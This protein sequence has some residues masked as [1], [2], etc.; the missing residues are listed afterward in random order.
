MRLIKRFGFLLLIAL[1]DQLYAQ[2]SERPKIV[3]GI[4]V[5]QMRFDYLQRFKAHFTEGGFKRLMNEGVNFTSMHY[6]YKPTMTA[7]GHASI[8]TGATPSMHGVVGN[9]WYSRKEKSEVYC[10]K[11]PTEDGVGIYSPQRMK[12]NTLADEIKLSLGD[13]SKSFG[14]SLKDRGAILPAG[15][16]AD[17]AYW[18]EG[19][20]GGFVSSEY[21]AQAEVDWVEAF[22]AQNFYKNYLADGWK[23]LRPQEIYHTLDDHRDY[24]RPFLKG[25]RTAFPYALKSAH[26]VKGDDLIKSTPFG[27]QLLADFAKEVILNNS[28][29]EDGQLDFFSISFSSTDYIGH[30]FGVQSTE[31]MDTYLRLDETLADL[32]SFFDEQFE[33]EYVVFLTADH[34]ASENRNHLI[35]KG[36]PAGYLD[37]RTIE[38][39]LETHL[40]EVFGEADWILSS[41]NLNIY[42][43]SALFASA[44]KQI[45]RD[46]VIG[47]AYYFLKDQEG[48][49]DVYVPEFGQADQFLMEASA[50]GFYPKESGD[51]VLIEQ[52]NWNAYPETGSGHSS[53]YAYD[54]HVP[55]MIMGKGIAGRQ[56]DQPYVI[57][58]IVPSLAKFLGTSLPDGVRDY[59]T[60]ELK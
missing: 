25:E 27:N 59:Q 51:L 22:N 18:F 3:V 45:E 4:V 2:A 60:M 23:L 19:E 24:E 1:M 46:D 33:G 12:T 40:D 47:A 56:E 14:I 28:L 43:N 5:D 41:N 20:Q 39:Q 58:D 13:R 16:M 29:G 50:R 17:G 8:F 49:L 7:A 26:K 42:L 54:T 57:T 15:H 35:K 9:G 52:T 32:L 34:G 21:Y 37:R 10:V 48:V 55:F 44:E 53:L 6:N 31:I 38:K 11:F 30:Q 36:I